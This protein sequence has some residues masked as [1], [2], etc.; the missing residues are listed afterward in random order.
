MTL[1]TR[2]T[3]CICAFITLLGLAYIY[4]LAVDLQ[5]INQDLREKLEQKR[6]Q[7]DLLLRMPAN[8]MLRCS[9]ADGQKLQHLKVGDTVSAQDVQRIRMIAEREPHNETHN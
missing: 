1:R 3:L 9:I 2:V 4:G 6:Q 5:Q 8:T 7:Y